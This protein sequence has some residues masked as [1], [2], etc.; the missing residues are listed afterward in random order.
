MSEENRDERKLTA[1]KADR[2]VD[3]AE[4]ALSVMDRVLGWFGRLFGKK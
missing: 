2:I 1:D 4:K 3:T